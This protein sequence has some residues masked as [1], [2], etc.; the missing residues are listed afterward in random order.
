MVS[1][2]HRGKTAPSPSLST[3]FS[4]ATI[5]A[6]FAHTP[7]TLRLA[8][9]AAP[10]M[11]SVLGALTVVAA[12]LPLAVAYVGK[13]IIDAVVAGDAARTLRLV[14]LEL[15]VIALQALTLRSLG[16]VRS[17]LGARLSIDINL[18][19]LR[20]A[21]TLDLR[22][23]EDPEFYDQLTRAR[24]EASSRPLS[25]ISD[26]FT[27]IQNVLTLGGYVALL[28]GYDAWAVAG[29]FVAALPAAFAE[30]HFSTAA[31][32]LRNWRSPETRRLNYVEFVLANDAH[33]KEVKLFALGPMLLE[34]YR[35]IG[36]KL[37]GEDRRLAVRRA[38]WG[39]GLSLIGT[40]AFYACYGVMA[41]AAAAG[42][43]T[44]G[45]LTL[46][47]VAFRQGQQ[48][49]Q[50]ILSAIGGMYENNLY[51][52]NL[53]QY[54][55]IAVRADELPAAA[56]PPARSAASERGIR[57]EHVGFKYPGQERW[58]LEDVDLFI[59]EGR[60]IA[61]VGHNGAGK[62]TFIK[63][64]TRLYEPTRGRILLD[65]VDLREWDAEAL[66]RRVGVV[67]QDFNRYQM[68]LAEN[69]GMGSIE[70]AADV[71]RLERAI[72]SGGARE[73]VDQLPQ[74]LGSPLGRWFQE[75]TEL[76]GGQWQRIALAR[77]F[78]R[79]E[80]DILVLD[81]P[82]A[83]L[84]AEAEFAVFERFRQLTVGRTTILISHRFPTVRQ[85]DEIVVIEGG[86]ILERGNHAELIAAGGRY[87]H[88]FS[89]QA[90]GYL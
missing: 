61:L 18:M 52:S 37:Y 76:S 84:D 66:R 39:Y 11:S 2:L 75:G 69:V 1:P 12:L 55:A 43:L 87:A 64:L 78:M 5:R 4:L 15:A 47:V 32:R 36:E 51:M 8:W 50:S 42:R 24:R 40:A 49:F 44:L 14:L 65:G 74:G 77:A 35:S 27:L 72:D 56:A 90:R 79:E 33:A 46:Y 62:T 16:L 63:L 60:S 34:L 80:A 57:F 89:V 83:A 17:L 20:K 13:V 30:M 29:L 31:F 86:R 26:T 53:F 25:V 41:V 38:A 70:H 81:E 88:L 7:R 54:L 3:R 71:P 59:P 23:F 68:T 28:I 48:A 22:H 45:N 85:A 21:Q 9:S 19:I 10:R 58:A 6:S 82:T 67:F 73:V